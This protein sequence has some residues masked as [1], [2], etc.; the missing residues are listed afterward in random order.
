M[1]KMRPAFD[2]EEIIA[3]MATGSESRGH[4]GVEAPIRNVSLRLFL[5][6]AIVM[7]AGFGAR[8][9]VL[10]VNQQASLADA[11]AL[12]K[13]RTF[14]IS[15][16]RGAILDANNTVL[17]RN[18]PAFAVVY[19]PLA[20]KAASETEISTALQ[21]VAEKTEI[22]TGALADRIVEH[23]T[24]SD[25][26]IL[27]DSLS[28]EAAVDLA[29]LIASEVLRVE[30]YTRRLYTDRAASLA[31][32]TGYVGAIS[33]EELL[34]LE[35]YGASEA[36]GKSGVERSWEATLRG[37]PGERKTI[38]NA[39]GVAQGQ[40]Q[41]TEPEPGAS[42]RLTIDADLNA[43][44]RTALQNGIRHSGATGGAAVLIDPRSGAVR[45]LASLPDFDAQALSDGLS[46]DAYA[47]LLSDPRTPFLNR[48]IS[49]QYPAGS[50]FKPF[51]G[52]AALAE[53]IISPTRRLD[54]SAGRITVTSVFDPDVSWTFP[55]WKPHGFVNLMEALARSSNVYFYMVGGGYK[56]LEGLGVDRLSR[57]LSDFGFGDLLNIDLPNE[58]TGRVPTPE[59]K[60]EAIGEGWYIGDTYNMSIGQGN[61]AVTPLQLAAATAAVANGGTLYRPH[62]VGAVL[63][64]DG[65]VQ[66]ET[67][68][69]VL[70]DVPVDD[71]DLAYVREGMRQAVTASYGT[72]Q[73]LASLPMSVA[74]KTGTA[75]F[76][77]TG[78][79][80]ALV[81]AFA[82]FDE[83]ELALAIL[84]EGGGGGGEATSVARDI[85]EWYATNAENQ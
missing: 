11:A 21:L 71:S 24:R 40:A 58:A 42:I 74:A 32:V 17:V 64:P 3:D 61:V 26:L 48:A 37:T 31:M 36:V 19:D 38:V 54:A 25:P 28:H 60:R 78:D 84:L 63:N 82:P 51:V 70:S 67:E 50:T 16:N 35:G 69:V 10:T 81:T 15:P 83:P 22:S 76:G 5:F 27:V 46:G 59:W 79:T 6:A 1:P 55:D 68:S 29:S 57:Y 13:E 8:S 39:E 44:V 62:V 20:A 85:I 34:E 12:A 2:P 80:H 45:A 43:A 4:D 30:P 14:I 23:G 47:R 52:S 77:T 66:K 7:L 56:D 73:L 33:D 75:Q 65:S 72:N 9:Y 41:E 49:G 53:D 18:E